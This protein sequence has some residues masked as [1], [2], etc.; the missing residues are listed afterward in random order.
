M[1]SEPHPQSMPCAGY[2]TIYGVN[3]NAVT[4]LGVGWGVFPFKKILDWHDLCEEKVYTLQGSKMRDA[5]FLNSENRP[6]LGTSPPH[7]GKMG[8]LVLVSVASFRSHG[9]I[10][11]FKALTR[12]IVL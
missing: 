4:S 5:V 9:N 8:H 2:V 10:L 3:L 7:H 11:P 12:L 1:K 6:I